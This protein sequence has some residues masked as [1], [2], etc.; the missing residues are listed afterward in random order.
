MKRSSPYNLFFW[1]LLFFTS[2][3]VNSATADKSAVVT[4]KPSLTPAFLNQKKPIPMEQLITQTKKNHGDIVVQSARRTTLEQRQVTVIEFI[5]LSGDWQKIIFDSTTGKQLEQ[6]PMKDLL[7]IEQVVT[8][9]LTRHRDAKINNSRRSIQDGNQVVIIELIDTKN[10]RWEMT[11]DAHTG[12]MIHEY[13]YDLKRTGKQLSLVHIIEKAREA[14]KGLVV[15]RTRQIAFNNTPA[16]ELIARDKFNVRRKMI[17]NAQ[18]GELLS[19]KPIS[20]Y[21]Y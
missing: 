10:K 7:P 3:I 19:N 14:E 15:L 20:G 6:V 21:Q 8:K 2:S 4:A 12:M 18:S 9:A 11:L 5:D 17:F 1:A 13:M 16:R